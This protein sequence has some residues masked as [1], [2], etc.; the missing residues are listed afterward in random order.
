[1]PWTREEN[2]IESLLIWRQN[3]SK[4]W[5][6][7][8]AESLTIISKKKSQICRWVHKFLA[9]G[10]VNNLGNK[11]ENPR[12]GRKSSA[13]YHDNVETVRDSVGGNPK[14]SLRRCSQELGLSRALLDKV[15][16]FLLLSSSLTF[17]KWYGSFLRLKWKINW[18][19]TN[20]HINSCIYF[21]TPFIYDSWKH[22]V[23]NILKQAWALFCTQL[24]VFKY[25]HITVTI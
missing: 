6:Q 23:D 18:R 13:R 7:N 14:K 5:K 11:A 8:F 12:S 9:T 2:Y 24:N 16:Q 25:W 1:M 22:F 3:H 17:V 4:L 10:S 19:I 15:N 21:Q 20:Y